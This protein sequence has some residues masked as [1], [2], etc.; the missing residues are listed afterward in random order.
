M[1]YLG[2]GDTILHEIG[3][4]YSR[5]EVKQRSSTQVSGI[6]LLVRFSEVDTFAKLNGATIMCL[7]PQLA[8]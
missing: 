6:I 3:L 1:R 7:Y 5:D 8:S 2:L 4:G